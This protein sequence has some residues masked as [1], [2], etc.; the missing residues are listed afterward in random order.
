[1]PPGSA[2]LYRQAADVREI[3]ACDT[4]VEEVTYWIDGRSRMMNIGMPDPS[5]MPQQQMMLPASQPQEMV[6]D[7]LGMRLPTSM[8]ES[9]YFWA[10]LAVAVVTVLLVSYWRYKAKARG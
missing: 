6:I 5:Q 7:F 8:L 1:M 3:L 4:G 2:G 9:G 10:F